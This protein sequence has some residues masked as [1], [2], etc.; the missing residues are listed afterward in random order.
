ARTP[1]RYGNPGR[2][3]SA[4]VPEGLGARESELGTA[5]AR[6]QR[7]EPSRAPDRA[8]R[9]HLYLSRGKLPV[10]DAIFVSE[11]SPRQPATR[12]RVSPR[13]PARG[14]CA[15]AARVTP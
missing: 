3:D 10:R 9:G 15:L 8:A 13:P 2:P 14:R 1:A 6:R 7:Q 11:I 12:P 4:A 5:H